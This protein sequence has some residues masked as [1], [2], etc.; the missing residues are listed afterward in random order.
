MMG[1]IMSKKENF[2]AIYHSQRRPRR[3]HNARDK[4]RKDK[5][6]LRIKNETKARHIQMSMHFTIKFHPCDETDN[7]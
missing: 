6:L 1:T 7:T 2:N 4:N 3:L 5:L